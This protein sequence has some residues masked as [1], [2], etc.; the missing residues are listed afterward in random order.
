MKVFISADIEGVSGIAEWN[1][2][3]NDKPEYAYFRNE[4]TKEVNAAC[5]GAIRSG[6]NEIVI[7][8]AHGNGRNIDHLE[9]PQNVKLIR[10]FSGHPFSMMF[11]IDNSFDAA[12]MIGYHSLAGSD[13]SPLTHTMNLDV[14][15]V[16]IN[17]K[18]ASEFMINAYTAAY[19]NVPVILV[20]GDEQLCE[21]VNEFNP[22]I[23]TV[24]LNK[25]VGKSVFCLH[26]KVSQERIREG[27]EE[28]LKSDMSKC[29][30]KLPNHFDIEVSYRNHLK[31]Y[32]SSFYPGM[33]Q[34][35]PTSL[36]FSSGDYFD[37]LKM[38]SFTL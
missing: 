11:G 12:I 10:S 20:S 37:V 24:P 8:D 35:S 1:E 6:A 38:M 19:V 36:T 26:P 30:I 5:E 29:K 15:Y 28:S 17:G 25:G 34:L 33:K 22:N 18:M 4:M 32:R 2:T 9:L 13:G 27:V 7:K 31:A 23:K 16:K 3:D 14:A 21:H